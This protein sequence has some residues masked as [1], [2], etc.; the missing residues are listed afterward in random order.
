MKK[1]SFLILLGMIVQLSYSQSEITSTE[2]YHHIEFLSHDTLQGRFPGTEG[3]IISANYIKKEF[4]SYGLE[5]LYD[6]GFQYFDIQ[7]KSKATKKSLKIDNFS[8]KYVEEYQPLIFSASGSFTSQAVFAGYGMNIQDSTFT[9]NDYENVDV[10]GKWVVIFRG[11]PN[12]TGY[13]ATFFDDFVKPYSKVVEAQDNGAVGVIFINPVHSFSN[14]DLIEPCFSRVNQQAKIPAFSV[15]RF[16]GDRIFKSIGKTVFEL[17]Q[18]IKR[19]NAPLNYDLKC[20]ISAEL[21][22]EPVMVTTQNVVA[23]LPGNDP[24]LS[25][26]Y[27]VIG[28]HYDHLGFGGCGSGSMMPDTLAVHNGADDNAS[29]VAGVLEIAEFLANHNLKRSVIFVA[30]G[31]EERGLLGSEFFVNN[32]PVEKDS[33]SGMLNFDMIGKYNGKLSILGTGT[34]VEFEDLIADIEIDTN[35]FRVKTSQKAYSGSDHA[36][37]IKKGIPALFFYASSGK[38]YHTPLDDVQF[39]DT[40]S[41]KQVLDFIADFAVLLSNNDKKLTFQEVKSQAHNGGNRHGAGGVKFGIVPSFEDIGNVGLK[42]GDVVANGPAAT[43]GMLADDIITAINDQ[44]ITNI[45]DYMA[46]LQKLKTGELVKV[47]INRNGSELELDVQL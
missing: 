42:V 8:C 38:D 41:E 19:N 11:A 15:K 9:W 47:K 37:F 1:I 2:I 28:A 12:V 6:E 18:S 27:I 3:D 46:R 17:E 10:Q 13:P 16:T 34:A 43:A 33:I 5:L 23:M 45:Y 21:E 24:V 25:E 32:L 31:A 35:T 26:Q 39:V 22:I 44:P 29:G 20:T 36:S 7:T 14:D 40:E 4:Q 30:F